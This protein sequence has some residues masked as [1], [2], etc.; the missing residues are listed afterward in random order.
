MSEA[1][2]ITPSQIEA[3]VTPLQVRGSVAQ[4]VAQ[5]QAALN[6]MPV[7]HVPPAHHRSTPWPSARS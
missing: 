3:G 6:Q 2:E 5:V 7:P 4:R 1:L